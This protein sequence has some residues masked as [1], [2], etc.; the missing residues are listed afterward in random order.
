MKKILLIGL[1]SLS[2]CDYSLH[3]YRIRII[4]CDTRQDKIFTKTSIFY[5]DEH[6]DNYK[7]AVPE[8]AG[9][10]NVCDVIITEL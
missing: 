8:Y 9:E 7:N 6:I 1:L 4:Y 5:P 10:L 2:S 3:T